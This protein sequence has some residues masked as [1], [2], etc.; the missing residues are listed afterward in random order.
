MVKRSAFGSIEKRAHNVYRIRWT[1]KDGSRKTETV[2]GP[3]VTAQQ[4]LA[5]IQLGLYGGKSAMTY[6]EYWTV[7]VEPSLYVLAGNT[8]HEYRT[9]WT[10][11]L[12]PSVGN[13]PMCETDWKLVEDV[14]G[15]IGSTSGQRKAHRL[16]RKILN[17]AIRDQRATNVTTNPCDRSI[18]MR[19]HVKREK[20]LLESQEL[21]PWMRSIRG[22]KYEP[23]LL[24]LSGSGMRP[25]E[26]IGLTWDKVEPVEILGTTYAKVRIDSTVTL[27]NNRL[28]HKETKNSTSTRTVLIG[29]PWA[30]RILEIKSDGY[31]VPN[32]KNGPS[33]PATIAHNYKDWCATNNVKHVTMENMR[34]SYST[35]CG[36]AGCV[37]SLVSFQMGHAGGSTRSR[38]YQTSTLKGLALVADTLFE[39]LWTVCPCGANLGPNLDLTV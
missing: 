19:Q 8:Q 6:N 34:T 2:H 3:K 30:S 35:M 37:D 29:E 36:E 33:S 20:V 15:A 22:I 9:S 5:Q 12:E 27:V 23:L 38:H 1:A 32:A 39:Y 25:G 11:Y 28:E 13:M 18:H 14:I 21:I 17:M 26:A 7:T 10:R 24:I 16:W 4:R 31:L